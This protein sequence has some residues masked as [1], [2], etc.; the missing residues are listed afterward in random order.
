MADESTKEEEEG[1]AACRSE[2][3]SPTTVASGKRSSHLGGGAG[4]RHDG[5]PWGR[6]SQCQAGG[7]RATAHHR[8]SGGVE[9]SQYFVS[10]EKITTVTQHTTACCSAQVVDITLTEGLIRGYYIPQSSTIET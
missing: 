9:S 3:A 5:G 8:E 6:Q 4:S 2:T 10:G 1:E 7:A